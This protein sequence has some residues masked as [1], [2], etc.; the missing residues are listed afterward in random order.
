[1]HITSYISAAMSLAH[2]VKLLLC[3]TVTGSGSLIDRW[4]KTP[5]TKAAAA[6]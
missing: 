6:A 1:M 2:T 3:D 5:A 4:L